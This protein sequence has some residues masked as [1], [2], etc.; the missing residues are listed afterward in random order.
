MSPLRTNLKKLFNPKTLSLIAAFSIL[1]WAVGCEPTVQSLTRPGIKVSAAQLQIELDSLVAQFD[2]RKAS[3]EEQNKL[4][5]LLL[6]NVMLTA[7]AGTFNPIGLL[8]GLMALY[9]V[10]SAANDTGKAIKKRRAK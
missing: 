4:R 6:S 9:G 8:T 2:I 7:Q 5:E 3:L 1:G 10:G